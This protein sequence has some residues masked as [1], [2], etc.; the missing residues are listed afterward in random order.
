MYDG[1]VA[2]SNRSST[3]VHLWKLSHLLFSTASMVK[4]KR[5]C[6]WFRCK[7]TTTTTKKRCLPPSLWY[8][9]TKTVKDE[10]MFFILRN[11]RKTSKTSFIRFLSWWQ[12]DQTHEA[13]CCCDTKSSKVRPESTNSIKDWSRWGRLG[14]SC[15]LL[16]SFTDYISR[17]KNFCKGVFRH[18]LILL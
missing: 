14:L 18:S 10:T 12:Q 15:P 8:M 9:D 7:K 16:S 3:L 6:V 17:A 2:D 5:K 4:K 1:F 13:S 11:K